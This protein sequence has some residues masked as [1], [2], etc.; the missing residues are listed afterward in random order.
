MFTGC[1]H[2]FIDDRYMFYGAKHKFTGY[3]YKIE[4][5]Y[6]KFHKRLHKMCNTKSVIKGLLPNFVFFQRKTV[7]LHQKMKRR[8]KTAFSSKNY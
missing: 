2:K 1:E 4:L 5:R 3:N 7:T 6:G 8:T